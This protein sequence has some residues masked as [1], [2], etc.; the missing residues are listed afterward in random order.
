MRRCRRFASS[1]RRTPR[2]AAHRPRASQSRLRTTLAAHRHDSLTRCRVRL[3]NLR[4][5]PPLRTSPTDDCCVGD[6]RS[7]RAPQANACHR[8]S[9]QDKAQRTAQDPI[10]PC[11]LHIETQPHQARPRPPIPTS[12]LHVANITNNYRP[13]LLCCCVAS[14]LFV[15][16]GQWRSSEV[17]AVGCVHRTKSAARIAYQAA[18][19]DDFSVILR[20]RAA[21]PAASQSAPG[22]LLPRRIMQMAAARRHCDGSRP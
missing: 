5:H 13:M 1:R 9:R 10:F 16:C 18:A 14:I 11:R 2:F 19:I 8:R 22:G 21:R 15:H 12:R 6:A 3:S 20:L 17:W 4:A 7:S